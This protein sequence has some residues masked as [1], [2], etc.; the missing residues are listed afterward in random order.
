MFIS[1]TVDAVFVISVPFSVAAAG[2]TAPVYC[3]LTRMMQV[4]TTIIIILTHIYK[5]KS[6][7]LFLWKG[8]LLY[9]NPLPPFQII[10]DDMDAPE[11][12]F[13]VEEVSTVIKEVR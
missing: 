9:L 1:A 11:T 13:V 6:S 7:S 10:M 12:T 4:R 5:K 3:S 8:V 2:C